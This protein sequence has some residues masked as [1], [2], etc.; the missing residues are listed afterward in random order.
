M[1]KTRV[2]IAAKT[3]PT[4]S[5]KYDELVC[6]A[7]FLEDGSWIR[8]YPIPF[9]KKSYNEQYSKY[10]W[11]EIDLVKN[12]SDFRPE[13]YRPYSYD[14]EIKIV[15]KLDTKNY[16]ADRKKFALNNVHT[17]LASLIKDAHNKKICTS[18]AVFKPSKIIDFIA[19]EVEREWDKKKIDQLKAN[20]DQTNLFEHPEDPFDVVQKL[21]Y[22][23][24][25]IF[26]DDEGK[27]SKL[28]IEDWE[29]GQLY[30][31]CL[32]KHEGN[33]KKAIDDV[34]YKY[35]EDFA[36]TKDLHFFLGTSALH[37]YV[38]NNPFM[39]IGTFHPKIESQYSLALDF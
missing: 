18:L 16:W 27:Q 12:K 11:V 23:F 37:H 10:D 22:K 32:A 8:I 9:R 2:L 1:A 36:K 29:T 26:E 24:S 21:P 20:R 30:W 25:F 4:I 5:G 34:K 6:T 17:N 28:M 19:V 15:G 13:S 38:S 14:S 33:E 35:F 7:G 39:I 31:N 3:Y